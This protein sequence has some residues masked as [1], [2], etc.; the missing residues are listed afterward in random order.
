MTQNYPI[1]GGPGRADPVVLCS[2]SSGLAVPAD[3]TNPLPT[4]GTAANGASASGNPIYVAGLDDNGVSLRSFR[5]SS[6]RNLHIEGGSA[7][8]RLV[9][10]AASTNATVVKASA[11]KVFTITGYNAAA[12]LRYLKL[13]NKATAPT[14]GTDTPVFTY[15]LPATAAFQFQIPGGFQF[16]TGIGFALTTGVADADTGA[17]T[18]ADVT[19]LH[20]NYT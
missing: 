6:F 4:G 11:G 15:V 17:L 10:A 7:T 19:A 1:S 8:A 14:V 16:A 20:I 3:T 12:A 18:L 2:V 9:S 5:L 13:Y